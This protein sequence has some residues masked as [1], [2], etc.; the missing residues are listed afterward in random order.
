MER[1]L[2]VLQNDKSISRLKVT[3]EWVIPAATEP[4]YVRF[5]VCKSDSHTNTKFIT[6]SVQ[7]VRIL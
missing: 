1:M 3:S 5:A 7:K 6:F 4:N 2:S